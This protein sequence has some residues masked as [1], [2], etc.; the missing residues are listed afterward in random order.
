MLQALLHDI[1]NPGH[2]LGALALDVLAVAG[3][4]AKLQTEDGRWIIVPNS[5]MA[6]IV[7]IR[8]DPTP[9]ASGCEHVK[10]T[11]VTCGARTRDIQDHNLAL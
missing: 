10:A 3:V 4:I 2:I 6:S 7:L 5:V 9:K 8:V 1:L 11:R